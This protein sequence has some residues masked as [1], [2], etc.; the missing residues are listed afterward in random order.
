MKKIAIL[1]ERDFQDLE[2]FYPFYRLKE[3]GF[4]VMVL[5]TGTAHTYFGK[6]GISIT[7][8]ADVA[9]M[10]PAQFSAVIIPGGWAPDH[11]RLHDSVIEFVRNLY[12]DQKVVAAICHGGWILA[13][14]DIINGKHVTAYRAI[15]DDM[16]NAGG[17][18]EDKELVKDGNIITSRKPDDL[19]AFCKAIIDALA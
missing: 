14:A 4:D 5:G 9:D 19:P 10:D 6:Y 3:A 11:M 18:Y 15:K 13:S 1:V 12:R 16:I 7:V 17:L 2:V 8:D